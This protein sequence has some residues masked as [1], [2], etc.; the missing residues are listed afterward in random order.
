MGVFSRNYKF[1]N[2]KKYKKR[3]MHKRGCFQET[4]NYLTLRNIKDAKYKNGGVF[5]KR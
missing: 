5:K 4:I 1:P 2:L 3:E